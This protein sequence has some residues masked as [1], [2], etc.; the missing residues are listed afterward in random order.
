VEFISEGQQSD[1]VVK[2][3]RDLEAQAAS[4][5]KEIARLK[6]ETPKPVDLP[7]PDFFIK[8][9]QALEDML[10]K[11]PLRGREQLHRL[12]EGGQLK[13]YPQLTGSYVAEGQFYPL[14]DPRPP[15]RHWYR[16]P[17]T[18]K[19]P[20]KRGPHANLVSWSSVGCAGRI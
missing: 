7:S 11:D 19:A 9:A 16:R 12:F 6:E 20:P 10:A 8:R 3:L 17:Q 5:K 15:A 4:E 2:S 1:Y 14:G 13:L 18:T